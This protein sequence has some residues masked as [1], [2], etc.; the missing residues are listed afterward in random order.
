MERLNKQNIEAILP[1]RDR[2]LLI[3]RV[4]IEN[5]KPVG[6]YTVSADICEGHFPDQPV[7]RGV[8]RIEMI[9]LMLGVAAMSSENT[10]I[11]KGHLPALVEVSRSIFKYP[12]RPGDLV[13]I[14]VE[15]TRESRRIIEGKGKA[16][17]GTKEIAEVEGLKA[18][19]V[20]ADKLLKSS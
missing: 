13:R 4:E 7:M 11:P 1:H 2:A 10:Q 3:D 14:E 17:V 12:A 8:D 19:V 9:G 18:V 6:Y 20:P 5:G 16:F 15:L